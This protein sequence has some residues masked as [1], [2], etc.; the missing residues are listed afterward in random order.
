MLI[1]VSKQHPHNKVTISEMI[2]WCGNC[3][4]WTRGRRL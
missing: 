1:Y 4:L 2:A 3:G